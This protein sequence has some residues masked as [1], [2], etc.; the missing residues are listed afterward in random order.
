M[1]LSAKEVKSKMETGKVV[2]GIKFPNHL[3]YDLIMKNARE[4]G[5]RKFV[6]IPLELLEIDESYQRVN[7]IS[8]DK[9][10]SLISNFDMNKCEPILV[11][12][13]PETCTFAVINGCHRMIASEVLKLGD[14]C[15]MIAEGLP[16]EPEERRIK[17]AELFCEQNVHVDHMAPA[18]KHKAYVK[19]GIKKYV[20][21]DECVKKRK[22]LLNVHELKNMDKGKQDELKAEGYKVLSG[23]SAALATAGHS[24]G[25]EVLNTV[26][27]IIEATAWH[28]ASGGYGANIIKV[29]S[30]MVNLYN[31]D[32][33]VTQAII[34]VL[35]PMEPKIF[36]S[37]SLAKYPGR[38]ES[39][40]M[41][42]FLD[43]E[44]ATLLKKEPKYTGGDLRKLT[45][46]LN[47]KRDLEK[48]KSAKSATA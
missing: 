5:G 6:S 36:L 4:I 3:A 41:L 28:Y 42:M 38:R 19:M 20:V 2:T 17:E 15:A 40:A 45:I 23:Y 31:M 27:D 18:H 30:S 46:V 44:V 22:L 13:H 1:M 32:P 33:V 14:M 10:K 39:E 26:F 34:N 37:K 43:Q 9:V 24:N 16:T 8:K 35:A 21:L 25:S 47:R 7:Y 29:L 48:D 11:A 12:P